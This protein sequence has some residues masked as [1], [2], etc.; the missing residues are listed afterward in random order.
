MAR[1]KKVDSPLENVSEDSSA[2]E[3]K[4]AVVLDR[5]GNI[6]REYNQENHG[7]DY[8]SLAKQY[9]EKIGGTVE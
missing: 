7:K 4:K 9:A 8:K 1:T 3:S 6:A 2:E 5:A